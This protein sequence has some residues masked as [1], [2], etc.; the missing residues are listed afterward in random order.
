MSR[1]TTRRSG[2][3]DR[4]RSRRLRRAAGPAPRG[5]EGSRPSRSPV[6]SPGIRRVSNAPSTVNRHADDRRADA[7][8]PGNRDSPRGR[9]GRRRAATAGIVAGSGE[10]IAAHRGDAEQVEERA[11][12][13]PTRPCRR[14]RKGSRRRCRSAGRRGGGLR[15]PLLFNGR[16]AIDQACPTSRYHRITYGD[17]AGRLRARGRRPRQLTKAAAAMQGEPAVAVGRHPPPRS[18]ARR[19]AVPPPRAIRVLTD[20]GRPSSG[21]PASSSAT[22]TP[23]SS[24]SPASGPATPARSTSSA[25]STLAADPLGRL[26]GRFRKAHPGVAVRIVAPDDSGRSTRW[27]STAGA[28]WGSP[29]CRPGTTSWWRSRS[30][31]RRSW[32]SARR[33]RVT[34]ARAAAGREAPGDAARDHPARASPT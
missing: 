32:R 23:S 13:A 17:C 10:A 21:P 30:N 26:V 31:A 29:S 1:G 4:H 15:G 28:S 16:T 19:A 18:R 25:L 22:P 7:Q 27:C 11:L 33:G 2:S 3:G 12:Q 8:H 9:N 34:G 14:R 6:R 24:R 20:A 5:R